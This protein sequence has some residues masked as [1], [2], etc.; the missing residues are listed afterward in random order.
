MNNDQAF[1]QTKKKGEINQHN[2]CRCRR[3][4]KSFTT[5]NR[6]PEDGNTG[7]KTRGSDGCREDLVEWYGRESRARARALNPTFE[8]AEHIWHLKAWLLKRFH[9]KGRYVCT[10]SSIYTRYVLLKV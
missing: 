8:Y 6:K 9:K 5:R 3:S 10:L 4:M 1:L 2:A 7:C